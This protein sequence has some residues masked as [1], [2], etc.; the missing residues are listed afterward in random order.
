M[1]KRSQRKRLEEGT[2]LLYDLM[3]IVICSPRVGLAAE[4]IFNARDVGHKIAGNS[5]CDWV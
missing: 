1:C 3:I 4:E 5:G 2:K